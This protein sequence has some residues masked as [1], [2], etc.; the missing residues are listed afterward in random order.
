MTN[1]EA[2]PDVAPPGSAEVTYYSSSLI[3]KPEAEV[4]QVGA[5]GGSL[6][7]GTAMACCTSP[8]KLKTMEDTDSSA[9]STVSIGEMCKICELKFRKKSH[10]CRTKTHFL[11]FLKLQINIFCYFKNGKKSIFAPKKCLKL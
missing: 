4:I 10:F 8:V 1:S 3:D 9:V 5:G 6:G 11:T 7:G 2:A